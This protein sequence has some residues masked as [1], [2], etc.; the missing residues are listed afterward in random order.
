MSLKTIKAMTTIVLLT[1]SGITQAAIVSFT[2]TGQV[3]IAD[4]ANFFDLR[5]GDAVTA[6]GVFDDSILTAGSGTVFFNSSTSATNHIT[7]NIGSQSVNETM[8]LDY[9]TSFGTFLALN[10]GVLADLDTFVFDGEKGATFDLDSG[11][12]IWFASDFDGGGS[13]AGLW[14]GI[15]ISAVPV[16]AAL[17]LFGSGLIGLIGVARRKKV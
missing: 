8:D 14:N 17:W 4:P 7:F 2:A 13:V 10:A 9:F 6:T 11:R 3:T 16:P 12:G 5:V 1:A 15:T